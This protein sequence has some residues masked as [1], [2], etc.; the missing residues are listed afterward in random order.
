[1]ANKTALLVFPR[2]Y[3]MAQGE[4]SGNGNDY[5]IGVDADGHKVKVILEYSREDIAKTYENKSIT[6]TSIAMMADTGRRARLP[7]FASPDNALNNPEGVIF[8]ERLV[9]PDFDP[10]KHKEDEEVPQFKVE[11]D[12]RVYKSGWASVLCHDKEDFED[13]PPEVGIGYV[14][15]HADR[16]KKDRPDLEQVQEKVEILEN[17]LHEMRQRIMKTPKGPDRDLMLHDARQ[18]QNEIDLINHYSVSLVTVKPDQAVTLK[19][20]NADEVSRAFQEI[21]E[22]LT[23]NGRY[24][25][26]LLRVRSGDRVVYEMCNEI[27]MKFK[28][29]DESTGKV[30]I[31]KAEEDF[32]E[33]LRFKKGNKIISQAIKKG[34]EIDLIPIQK[35]NCGGKGKETYNEIE[36]GIKPE[37][38]KV[39]LSYENPVTA[40]ILARHVV[41]R[42]AKTVNGDTNDLLGRAHVASE[43]IGSPYLLTKDEDMVLKF[44]YINPPPRPAEQEQAPERAVADPQP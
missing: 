37:I 10:K 23:V 14:S 17:E 11:G 25:G 36:N 12:M 34:L 20:K 44:H 15:L 2:E 21:A 4:K 7:A 1:M 35:L 40:D 39:R 8:F 13:R 6:H 9:S 28:G 38:N 24:G 29:F 41:A 33:F 32:S 43:A 30:R 19:P 22:P 31:S 26:A 3:H 18:L 5:V 16:F 27:S 42:T